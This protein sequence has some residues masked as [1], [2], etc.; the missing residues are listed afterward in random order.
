MI[1]MTMYFTLNSF[2]SFSPFCRE[3]ERLNIFNSNA[4]TMYGGTL[5]TED[6]FSDSRSFAVRF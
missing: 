1:K 5:Q 2:F 6:L 3:C 4:I